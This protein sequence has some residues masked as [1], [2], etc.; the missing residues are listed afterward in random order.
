MASP[1]FLPGKQD[2]GGDGAG[3]RDQRDGE[4][5][6]RG[7]L[8]VPLSACPCR[9][10]LRRSKS[11]SSAVRKQQDAARHAEGA[12]MEMPRKIQAPPRPRGRKRREDA[13]RHE[14]G[15]QRHDPPLAHRL[16]PP[17]GATKSGARPI[18]VDHGRN[19]ATKAGM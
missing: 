13:E 6:D 12:G 2:H 1:P 11:M 17:S 7:V 19:S 9:R 10:W 15:A 18:G 14:A 5:E 3:A 8:G 16:A 4:R